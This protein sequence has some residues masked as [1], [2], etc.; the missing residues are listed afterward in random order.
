V[1]GREAEV[2]AAQ[3]ASRAARRALAPE[4][5]VMTSYNTMWHD[6]EHRWMAGLGVQVPL[7]W[8]AR[9]SGVVAA[10]A[11]Q[12]AAEADRAAVALDQGA[13]A[14]ADRVDLE[15]A[16]ATWALLRDAVLPLARQRVDALR[17]AWVGGRA[18]LDEV[19][20]AER[21]LLDAE[22][23]VRDAVVAWHSARTAWQVDAGYLPGL[24]TPVGG[25]R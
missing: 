21:D 25:G 2:V 17:G 6:P 23:A 15:A 12:A 10:D 5:E 8:R 18:E 14:V 1:A 9:R 22:L 11:A 19:L 24:D 20:M 16:Y 4:L 3:A 7:W 13:A